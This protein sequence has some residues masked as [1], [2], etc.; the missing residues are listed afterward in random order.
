MRRTA[1]T[2]V[3]AV[4][5]DHSTSFEEGSVASQQ[6]QPDGVA[7]PFVPI[8]Q[9]VQDSV[10]LERAAARLG[11]VADAVAGHRRTG[12]MLRGTWFGHAIHPLLTDFPLGAWTCTSL[13]DLFG[14]RRSR[15]VAQGLLTFGV[16]MATPTAV[17]GLAEWRTTQGTARRVGAAHAMVNSTAWALYTSSLLA[18]RRD[19]HSLGVALGLAGG[20][21][22]I[23]GGYLGGHLSLVEKVGTGNRAWY[24][25]TDA[26]EA[27]GPGSTSAVPPP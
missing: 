26:A 20:L 4:V 21:S 6:D 19:R 18:R 8:M 23:V 7:S 22:A 17:T 5:V 11:T 16:A 9:R 15:P 2:A 27:P 14:G 25:A 24:A 10:R 12:D 1:S 13:L 3:R